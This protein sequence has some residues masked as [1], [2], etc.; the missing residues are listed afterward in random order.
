MNIFVILFVR[1]RDQYLRRIGY[2]IS[3]TSPFYVFTANYLCYSHCM[4]FELNF[5]TAND[6]IFRLN[7]LCC[8]YSKKTDNP[9]MNSS[10][11]IQNN[12]E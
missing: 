7:L 10:V 12:S 2:A 4:L 1:S 3:V 9:V 6:H 11:G 5:K 8:T